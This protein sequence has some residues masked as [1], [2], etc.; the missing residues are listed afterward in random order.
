VRNNAQKNTSE[1]LIGIPNKLKLNELGIYTSTVPIGKLSYPEDGN[2]DCFEMED[3]SFWFAQRNAVILKTVENY[4]PN[5]AIVD[6]GGGNGF[7]SAALNKQGYEAI[8][9]EP[10]SGAVNGKERGLNTVINATLEGAGFEPGSVPAIGIFDVLEHIEK[11][12]EWLSYIHSLLRPGGLLYITVPA[13]NFLWSRDDINASH[14]KRYTIKELEKTLAA[15]GLKTCYSSYF[16]SHLVLPIFLFRALPSRFI[17][18]KKHTSKSAKD[19]QLQ[20]GLIYRLFDLV[21]RIELGRI[22]AQKKIP[23]GSSIIAVASKGT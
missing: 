12:C 1:D 5:G 13:F 18:N 11:H 4:P 3:S 16:F 2:E 22:Q 9:L 21:S 7:V 8:L 20:Q 6:V 23:F 17:G 14:F 19:H 10:G 15:V